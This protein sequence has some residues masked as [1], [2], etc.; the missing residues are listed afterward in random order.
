MLELGPETPEGG[1]S[2]LPCPPVFP[3][4]LTF[5]TRTFS[6]TLLRSSPYLASFS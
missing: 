6:F 4:A 5:P 2:L 3:P 1:S